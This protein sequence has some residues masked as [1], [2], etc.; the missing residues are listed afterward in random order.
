MNEAEHSGNSREK[1]LSQVLG[2]RVK[3]PYDLVLSFSSESKPVLGWRSTPPSRL[4]HLSPLYPSHIP[5]ALDN[6]PRY[7]SVAQ[8]CLGP[9]PNVGL[10]DDSF[11]QHCP[12]PLVSDFPPR[13][14]S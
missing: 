4:C 7:L 14:R 5:E 12:R 2:G 8:H 9:S 3:S 1:S 11:Y 13:S 10:H 6:V